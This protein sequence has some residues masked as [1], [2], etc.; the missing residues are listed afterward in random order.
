MPKLD[1]PK[2]DFHERVASVGDHPALLRRLGLVIELRVADPAR[3]LTS[4]WLSARV[5]P[6]GDT[7]AGRAD[8]G[9]L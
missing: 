3:L 7:K 4:D 2:P 6:R 1:P 8:P 5:V 9:A